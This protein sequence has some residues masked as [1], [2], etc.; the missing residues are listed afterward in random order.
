MR[1]LQPPVVVK[2]IGGPTCPIMLYNAYMQEM[3]TIGSPL[4]GTSGPLFR[5]MRLNCSKN[6]PPG[7]SDMRVTTAAV[8]LSLGNSLVALSLPRWGLPAI[9]RGKVAALTAR[10]PIEGIDCIKAVVG[11]RSA[12]TVMQDL[13]SGV[14][15]TPRVPLAPQ[16]AHEPRTSHKRKRGHRVPVTVA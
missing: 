7:V 13:Y 6:L 1:D 5:A 8:R 14:H 15:E 16:V 10:G 12:G 9:K 4:E 11:W 2:G 3:R